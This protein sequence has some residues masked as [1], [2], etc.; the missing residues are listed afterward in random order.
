MLRRLILG[1]VFGLIVGGA[2]AFGLVQLGATSFTTGG[3]AAIAY[4][5]SAVA[6]ALT[7]AV[8]NHVFCAEA[9]ASTPTSTTSGAAAALLSRDGLRRC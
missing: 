8:G 9:T 2:V 7:G 6:G 1:L 3:G 4:L 5:S